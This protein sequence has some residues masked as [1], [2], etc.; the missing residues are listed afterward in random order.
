M[1]IGATE[2]VRNL[3]SLETVL[4]PRGALVYLSTDDP[5]GVCL[6]CR[7]KGIPCEQYEK[8]KKPV[9]CPEDC[10]WKAFS[11]AGKDVVVPP[12]IHW[13]LALL[14]TVRVQGGSLDFSRIISPADTSRI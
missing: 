13:S 8:G 2:I 3:N 11:D 5:D 1:K 9:G 10:S 6:G 14:T 4:I 7:V 12:L